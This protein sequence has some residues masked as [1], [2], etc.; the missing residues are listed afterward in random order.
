VI[1]KRSRHR[2]ASH[3]PSHAAGHEFVTISD[4]EEKRMLILT[5]RLSESIRIGNDITITV[6][7][8]KG[9]QIRLGI[10]A[11]KSVTVHREEV[12]ERINKA[13]RTPST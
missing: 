6:L 9:N 2:A 7:A 3:H 12:Y 11:P 5:R 8:V 1:A 13:G 4:D 10:D